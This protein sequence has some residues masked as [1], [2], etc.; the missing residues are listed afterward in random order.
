[1]NL[2]HHPWNVVFLAGF[3]AYMAIRHVYMQRAKGVE[4]AVSRVDGIEKVLLV[5]VF[6][7]SLLLPMLYLF[8]PLLAF[9]DYVPAR[10]TPWA[11]AGAMVVA[12]WLFWRSHADLGD[13]W[14]MSLEVRREHAL[15]SHGVYRRMRHPMYAAIILFGAAQALLLP[16]WLAGFSA[17]VSFAPM[18]IV[19]TPREER[20]MIETFGA[21]YEAYARRTWRVFPKPG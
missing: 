14:S 1:V 19:R 10:A 11:G 12:L 4:T 8:T 13:N 2:L 9:A 20:L 17:L 16:N 3:I 21:E 5:V 6:A 7:G 15:V 18:Y